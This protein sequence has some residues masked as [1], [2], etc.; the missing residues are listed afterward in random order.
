MYVAIIAATIPALRPL[1]VK[2]ANQNEENKRQARRPDNVPRPDSARG[3][4]PQQKEADSPSGLETRTTTQES[5]KQGDVGSEVGS[6]PDCTE[7]MKTS[8]KKVEGK[9]IP[10][11]SSLSDKE[12]SVEEM[13]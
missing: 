8:E 12:R 3:M 2:S 7:S 4:I 11:H 1:W 5:K 10:E 9:W 6:S 13:V